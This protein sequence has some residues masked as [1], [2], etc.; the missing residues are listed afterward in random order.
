[1]LFHKW[2]A[3]KGQVCTFAFFLVAVLRDPRPRPAELWRSWRAIRHD[4]EFNA[5]YY[6]FN[7]SSHRSVSP[8]LH[9][10]AQ[11]DRAR[12]R[13]RPVAA[14]DP[15]PTSVAAARAILQLPDE[16]QPNGPLFSVI[17][18]TRNRRTLLTQAVASVLAQQER[19]FE[20]LVIDDGS[21]PG[22]TDSLTRAFPDEIHSER[23]K[24][25]AS[26]NA[27]VGQGAA[28][29]RNRGLNVARGRYVAYLDSDNVWTPTHLALH[30]AALDAGEVVSVSRA[31]KGTLGLTENA[32]RDA[33]L[34]YNALDISGL[35]HARALCER[36]GGFDER[37]RRLEDYDF[38]LRITRQ[39]RPLMIDQP[40][41]HYRLQPDSLTVQK[42]IAQ[43][44]DHVAIAHALERIA[45]GVAPGQIIVSSSARGH[46]PALDLLA[47][48]FHAAPPDAIESW[49]CMILTADEVAPS[50]PSP[51][52]A[53]YRLGRPTPGRRI[54]SEAGWIG[55]RADNDSLSAPFLSVAEIGT[56][57]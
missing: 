7:Q 31:L 33:Q 27:S 23:L 43:Y 45:L 10:V 51:R 16:Q 2:L 15:R 9:Y 36:L 4:P 48:R 30:R 34:Q 24:I 22:E 5:A 46:V 8:F 21:E 55:P 13:G 26:L 25:L 11:D 28:G 37:L 6:H 20:V 50:D 19:D 18:P 56:W 1:M 29:A 35:C 14:R 47:E 38:I 42:P 52:L 54:G 41:Y 49:T 32:R 17:I 3:L 40:T 44:R 57:L 53:I 39:A 12:A